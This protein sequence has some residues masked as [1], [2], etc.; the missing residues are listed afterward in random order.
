MALAETPGQVWSRDAL[1]ERVWPTLHVGEEVLTH[2]IAELRRAF[3]D[4]FREPRYLATIHKYGYRLVAAAR[5][6]EADVALSDMESASSDEPVTLDAYAAYLGAVEL[7]EQGGRENTEAASA[8]FSELTRIHPHFALAHSSLAKSQ[9][10]LS[11]YYRHGENTPAVLLAHC[12]AAR[13]INPNSADA[14]AAEGF[15]HSMLGAHRRS[16]LCFQAALNFAPYD[17]EI[18]YLLGRVSLVQ[19]D[20]AVAARIFERTVSLRPD[21]FRS[22]I[23]LAKLRE[24]LGNH[25]GAESVYAAALRRIED[26]LAQTPED[27]RALNG[28]ARCLWALGQRDEALAL[29]RALSNRPDPMNYYLACALAW[30]GE[31]T[32]ALDV[33]E[34]AIELGWRHKAWLD[35]DPDFDRL[36]D[37][38]RFARIAAAMPASAAS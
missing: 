12:A 37:H 15:I 24:A 2:A 20:L 6:A 38:P 9:T 36:R 13:R 17:A 14:L 26:Q 5:T 4:D 22:L 16:H 8:T 21:D 27:L 1:L 10:F 3:G 34:Q 18:H 7:Y 32:L 25:A 33:L 30:A 11:A 19:L 28:R 35:R 23:M 29:M 31:T